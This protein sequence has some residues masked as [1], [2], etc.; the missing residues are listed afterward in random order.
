[1]PMRA[2]SA[3]L[4]PRPMRLCSTSTSAASCA[5]TAARKASLLRKIASVEL[6]TLPDGTDLHPHRHLLVHA[7]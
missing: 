6:P 2:R 1:M 5:L 7:V 4:K 3:G